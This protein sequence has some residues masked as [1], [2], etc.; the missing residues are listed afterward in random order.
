MV[1]I[2]S[3]DGIFAKVYNDDGT[4]IGGVTDIKIGKKSGEVITA[5]LEILDINIDTYILDE[6]VTRMKINMRFNNWLLTEIEKTKKRLDSNNPI[7]Y[8]DVGI[9]YLEALE[10]VREKLLLI[11]EI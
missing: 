9:G 1:K 11:G 5:Q 10:K 4:Q 6:N 7:D 3:T 2:V 8:T